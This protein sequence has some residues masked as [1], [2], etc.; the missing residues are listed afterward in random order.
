[1]TIDP[2]AS[3]FRDPSGFV[4]RRQ[5]LLL[6]Y[7]APSYGAHYD[8][9]MGGGVYQELTEAQLLIPHEEIALA[10]PELADAHRILAPQVVPFVSYPYEWCFGQLKAAALCVLEI[11]RRALVRGMTLKD[12]SG[13]NIQF[14]RG[15]PIWIDTLSFETYREGAPWIAYRQFCEHFLAP[16]VL[17][18]RVHADARRLLREYLDGV[19]LEIAAAILGARAALSPA[20]LIHLRLHARSIRRHADT[21]A[22]PPPKASSMPL[23]GLTALIDSLAGA[24]R[25]LEWRPSGTPWAEYGHTHGYAEESLVAKRRIVLDYL[26]EARAELVWDLGA[27]TGDFSRLAAATG[28]LTVALDADPAA[29]ELNFRRATTGGETLILPLVMDLTNPSPSLGWGLRERMSLVDRGPADLLLALALVHHLA[30]SHN[31][32]FEMIAEAFAQLGRG[33]VIEFVPKEDPQAQRLLRSR[34]DIFTEYNREAFERAFCR[35]FRVTSCMPLPAS[36]RVLYAMTR[37][38][39]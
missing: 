22:T 11:Q 27:N 33:L 36:G 21:S 12:A 7:V 16:L 13:Y 32:P 23:S 4:F 34:E 28:A 3:S 35:F 1:V 17:M 30:I 20:V 39:M 14:H 37:D 10:E 5:G 15:R 9:L 18:A 19:P 31:L 2:I 38:G 26:R 24:V 6:R 8:A 25:G 29:V